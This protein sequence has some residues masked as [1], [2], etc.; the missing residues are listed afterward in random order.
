MSIKVKGVIF[1]DKKKGYRM[2]EMEK[3]KKQNKSTVAVVQDWNH[4]TY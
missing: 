3:I 2:G 1:E 4:R